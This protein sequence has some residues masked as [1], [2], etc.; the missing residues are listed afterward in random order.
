VK[1]ADGNVPL[2][3]ATRSR[4]AVEQ[5]GGLVTN[6]RGRVLAFPIAVP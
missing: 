2:A 6:L 4:I 5:S 1:R 3:F